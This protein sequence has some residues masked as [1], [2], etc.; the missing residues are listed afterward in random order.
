MPI[1]QPNFLSPQNSTINAATP[2]TFTATVQGSYADAFSFLIY[3]LNNNLTYSTPSTPLSTIL[4]QGDTFSYN[5]PSSSLTNGNQ[6]K[7][8]LTLYSDSIPIQQCFSYSAGT[9]IYTDE[10]T[11]ANNA[12]ANDLHLVPISA[13]QDAY[14]FGSTSQFSGINLTLGTPGVYS[15]TLVWEYYNS[16]TSAWI[17]IPLFT[18][19]TSGF[20][21]SGMIL[22]T[23]P[24]DWATVAV[25]SSTKYWIR[26]RV[27]AFTSKTTS[28]LGTQA[29]SK[30]SATSRETPFFC[31][32]TPTVTMSVASTPLSSTPLTINSKKSIF[33]G[34]YTQAEGV[35]LNY[36][37]MVFADNL[38]NIVSQT[39]NS[40][41][42]NVQYTFDGFLNNTTYQVYTVVV[43][44]QGVTSVSPTY[45][46]NVSY[47]NPSLNIVPTATLLPDLSAVNIA[48]AAPLQINGI[49]TGTSSYVSGLFTP[50]NTG[51]KLNTS[52]YIEY[53]LSIPIGFT[54][55]VDY[56]PD[57][58]FTSGVMM[59]LDDTSNLSYQIGYDGTKFYYN[60][61]GIVVSG[62]PKALPTNPFLIAVKDTEVLIISNNQIYEDL[63]P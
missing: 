44:Q 11:A 5:L 54:V 47:S 60:S 51:L 59:E 27:S 57:P 61:N 13:A 35:G 63:I 21:K 49:V 2:N 26:C 9:S 19:N 28:P 4:Y 41:S 50:T 42:G 40:Y 17:T 58:S 29:W 23:P 52:S 8:L 34:I 36:W 46:F 14:Y 30:T 31:Y 56:I 22:F 3:D 37:F 7:W 15:A 24:A 55:M 39:S 18:D 20:T 62:T 33:T 1:Y 48:W 16:T 25:N 38:G 6:F 12:I 10:T 43:N 45:P 53:D 32:S